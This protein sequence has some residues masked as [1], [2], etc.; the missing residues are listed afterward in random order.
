MRRALALL[1]LIVACT[2]Q[3]PTSPKLRPGGSERLDIF[4][5]I[6]PAP[7]D[8]VEIT[9]GTHHT[10]ARQFGGDVY[11]WGWNHHSQIGIGESDPFGWPQRASCSGFYC[12]I[13]PTFVLNARQVEAGALHTCARSSTT[14]P[15]G[16][17]NAL[18]WG[19]GTNGELGNSASWMTDRPDWVAGGQT[20]G[21]ISA[22][23]RSTC[24][25]SSQGIHCWG[26][27]KNNANT[28][29]L[30]P[31]G[32]GYNQVAVS[33]SHACARWMTTGASE[34]HCWGDNTA[35]QIGQDPAQFPTTQQILGTP[36]GG[37]VGPVATS[38]MFTCADQ[39]S[40]VVNCFGENFWSQLGNGVVPGPGMASFEYT[41]QTVLWRVCR[42]Y[43]Y[44][45][46]ATLHSVT[47]GYTHA[48]ALNV[49]GYAY[50]WGNGSDGQLGNGGYSRSSIAV[51]VSGGH[52]YRAIAAG[53]THTCAIGTDN[54]IYCWGDGMVG[55]L[56][57]LLYS[58]GSA[59]PKPTAALRGHVAPPK[60]PDA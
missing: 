57:T 58:D 56:G 37:A 26:G 34:V 48:C 55:Q 32:S 59:V 38:G 13:A 12:V 46:P 30:L 21:S 9:A 15:A 23:E 24:A 47:T 11:C 49:N 53:S 18:C 4:E 29:V 25:T 20:F 8:F 50:C 14:P 44:N 5:I 41:P 3:A 39:Q 45:A 6:L 54:V 19:W 42:K 28:P 10:C 2:E 40:G 60:P 22:G 33:G 16:K 1:A 43:C 51:P 17:S 52:T 7:T 35:G 36:L 27:I 31:S